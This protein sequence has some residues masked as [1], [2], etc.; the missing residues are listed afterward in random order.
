M[1]PAF[2][3]RY[4]D[5]FTSDG[6]STALTAQQ[7]PFAVTFGIV[8]AA[9]AAF[10]FDVFVRPEFLAGVA[11]AAAITVATFLIRW[12]RR[13]AVIA[14]V[15]VVDFVAIAVCRDASIVEA[16]SLAILAFLPALW[17][18]ILLHAKGAWIAAG[19]TVA[20][21]AVPSIARSPDSG[22][23]YVVI[24][25]LLTPL[26]VFVV[27]GIVVIMRRQVRAQRRRLR[28][29]AEQLRVSLA[30]TKQ[31]ENLLDGIIN[32]V[33]VGIL[34]IDSGGNDIVFNRAQRD[35]H[36]VASPPTNEDKTETG[37]LIY[38]T[39]GKTPL[40]PEDRPAARAIRGETFTGLTMLVGERAAEQRAL[41][42][43]ARPLTGAD[44]AR[45]GSVIVFY[46]VTDLV[47]TLSAGERFVSM[48]SHELRTPVTSVIGYLDL[49]EDEVADMTP[50]AGEYLAV[51]K[52]NAEQVLTLVDDLLLR[53]QLDNGRVKIDRRATDLPEL[54]RAAIRSARP[55]AEAKHITIDEELDTMPS[56][57]IDGVRMT[58]VLDNLLSNAIKY[59]PDGGRITVHVG[60]NATNTI[61]EVTDTGIG[62]SADETAGLFTDFYRAETAVR[63]RIRG[64]GLG[65]VVSK[66]IIEQ[67]HGFISVRSKAGA[68]STFR[69]T[70]PPGE[71]S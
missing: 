16:N 20:V 68:G 41:S 62:M 61:I 5:E 50:D 66:E 34:A 12:P 49:L 51:I 52:R 11:I 14:V 21:I 44:G 32:S 69:V 27:S 56:A 1:T 64:T 55:R 48:V 54:A 59:T 47:R 43:A 45:V 17:L 71:R 22:D 9:V 28:K 37:H 6:T 42:V 31:S 57:L 8:V 19:I 4:I 10:R 24:R 35:I 33:N 63:R 40:P 3:R 30:S 65:L 36:A 18:A 7:L 38:Q 53:A 29:Q 60:T 25:Y 23:P 39:D 70:I 15:P 46:D 2:L 67:H 13:A 26:V 58:Q